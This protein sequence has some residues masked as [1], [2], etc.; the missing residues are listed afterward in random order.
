MSWHCRPSFDGLIG[1]HRKWLGNEG[2]M[3][4]RELP[5]ETDHASGATSAHGCRVQG[6]S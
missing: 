4:S 5:A 1:D 3:R 6:I 2:M